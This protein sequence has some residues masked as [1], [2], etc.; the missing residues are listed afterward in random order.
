MFRLSSVP[1][2]F[3]SESGQKDEESTPPSVDGMTSFSLKEEST[4]ED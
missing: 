4:L 3:R 2:V 1:K